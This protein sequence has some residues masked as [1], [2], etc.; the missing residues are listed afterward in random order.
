MTLIELWRNSCSTPEN[1]RDIPGAEHRLFC[2]SIAQKSSKF[3]QG[4]I[5]TPADL[6]V[7]SQSN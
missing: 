1:S 4:R 5:R 7:L 2:A 6:S 3:N